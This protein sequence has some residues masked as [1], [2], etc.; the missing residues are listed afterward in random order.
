MNM[1]NHKPI[2]F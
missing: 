1:I 2:Q